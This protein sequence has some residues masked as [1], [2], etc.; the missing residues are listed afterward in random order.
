MM[1]GGVPIPSGT[2]Y[3]PSMLVDITKS[4]SEC[5]QTENA[6]SLVFEFLRVG[7]IIGNYSPLF[8]QQDP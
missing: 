6:R 4:T 5:G 8:L 3:L 7:C 2:S 1:G